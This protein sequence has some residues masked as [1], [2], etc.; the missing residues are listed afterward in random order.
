MG[1][2]VQAQCAD[3]GLDERLGL[4][5]GFSSFMT[6]A[7]VPAGC[8][9]C[10]RLVTV[11]AKLPPPFRCPTEGCAGAPLIIGDILGRG[12][13]ASR[14]T[15]FDWLI[16]DVAGTRYVLAPDPHRCPVCGGSHLT[17]A[18]TGNWD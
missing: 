13:V 1:T 17:F 12:D 15:V 16:D 18:A 2:I 14:H 8:D 11:N 3:C 7:A 9:I 10:H 4:G 6:I 5:G